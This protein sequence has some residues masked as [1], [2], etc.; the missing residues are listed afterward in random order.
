ML[1]GFCVN[2]TQLSNLTCQ[3]SIKKSA[4]N[5]SE[6][7]SNKHVVFSYID[8]FQDYYDELDLSDKKIS[9]ES[10]CNGYYQFDLSFDEYTNLIN[11]DSIDLIIRSMSKQMLYKEL[12]LW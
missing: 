7:L 1:S 8:V 9:F 11:E 6:E 10:F 12:V 3:Q 2:Y 4:L 5:V